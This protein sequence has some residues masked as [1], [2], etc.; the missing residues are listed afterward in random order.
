MATPAALAVSARPAVGNRIGRIPATQLVPRADVPNALV[1][2]PS[3]NQAVGNLSDTVVG[4]IDSVRKLLSTLPAN[5]VSEF[6]SG[7]LLMVR[8]AL[9]PDNP[10]VGSGTVEPF[11]KE[12]SRNDGVKGTIKNSTSEVVRVSFNDGEVVRELLPGQEMTYYDGHY[13]QF[14]DGTYDFFGKKVMLG[15]QG[16]SVRFEPRLGIPNPEPPKKLFLFDADFSPRT[17]YTEAG[18]SKSI[19][20][21]RTDW[22]AGDV[23]QEVSRYTDIKVTFTGFSW[24]GG[25]D[26]WWNSDWAVFNIEILKNE[27][28]GWTY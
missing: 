27:P 16:P 7:A 21:V 26:N 1:F 6:L 13:Q 9:I 17:R 23:H 18:F 10:G 8:R 19:F 22:K 28:Y 15:G 24:N 14:W 12:T 3:L 11:L 5:P 25:Y 4:L 20:T 2:A